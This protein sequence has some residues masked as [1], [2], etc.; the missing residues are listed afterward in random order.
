MTDT[1]LIVDDDPKN[2]AAAQQYFNSAGREG[3]IASDY[4]E[5]MAI[6]DSGA[7]ID[8]VLTDCFMPKKAG[9]GD[10]QLGGE[11]ITKIVAGAYGKVA[12]DLAKTSE[13]KEHR[14]DS[15][16]VGFAS[17]VETTPRLTVQ[18]NNYA[19]YCVIMES[20]IEPLRGAVGRQARAFGPKRGGESLE[21]LLSCGGIYDQ[22]PERWATFRSWTDIDRASHFLDQMR[23][24]LQAS[25]S[26]QPLGFLIA[27]ES[28]KRG[29][30][31]LIVSSAYHH[32][33]H[34][35]AV[36]D[37]S[38]RCHSRWAVIADQDKAYGRTSKDEPEAWKHFHEVLLR[39]AIILGDLEA[40]TEQGYYHAYD[41]ALQKAREGSVSLKDAKEVMRMR[42][43]GES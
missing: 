14:R 22:E 15:I 13:T 26:N 31:T 18:L 32:A 40:T 20:D 27:E 6:L 9:S 4:V 5:A 37:Y 3:V 11:A 29:L 38:E 19:S 34:I 25:E 33:G 24:Y 28:A 2:R 43:V 41:R 36:F 16:V 1:L 30:P 23:Q 39:E 7:S 21:Q 10:T 42:T 12:L 8:G 17:L 35:Q